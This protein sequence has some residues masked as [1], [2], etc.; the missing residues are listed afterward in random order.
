MNFRWSDGYSFAVEFECDCEND[1]YPAALAALADARTHCIKRYHEHG[2]QK[3]FFRPLYLH[4]RGVDGLWLNPCRADEQPARADDRIETSIDNV[5][6][7]D[8]FWLSIDQYIIWARCERTY[9]WSQEFECFCEAVGNMIQEM[10][11]KIKNEKMAVEQ[12][13]KM[14]TQKEL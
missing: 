5:S 9:I 3:M 2:Q 12:F 10:D 11:H 6:A 7:G 8:E 13:E 4:V 14:V 1:F